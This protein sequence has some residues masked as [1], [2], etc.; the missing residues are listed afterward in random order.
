MFYL[1]IK[2]DFTSLSL[3]VGRTVDILCVHGNSACFKVV[4]CFCFSNVLSEI[5][6]ECQIVWI[7]IMVKLVVL[8]DMIWINTF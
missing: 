7:Q 8:S 5:S 2:K 1:T 4:C 3:L 6:Q